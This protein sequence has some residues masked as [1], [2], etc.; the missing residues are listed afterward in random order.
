MTCPRCSAIVSPREAVCECGYDFQARR[1]LG[2]SS[3]RLRRELW[4]SKRALWAGA[5][6]L[7]FV[8][9]RVGLLFVTGSGERHFALL[10]T[11]MYFVDIPLAAVVTGV[12]AYAA[13]GLV[14]T[15]RGALAVVLAVVI[16]GLIGTES[17]LGG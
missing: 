3:P 2:P 16:A 5:A 8:L 12:V 1:V 14:K 11:G 15:A 7:V 4:Q 13:L 6:G 9:A 10:V 17:F